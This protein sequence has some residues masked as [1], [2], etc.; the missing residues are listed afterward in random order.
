MGTKIV[1]QHNLA[2]ADTSGHRSRLVVGRAIAVIS[3]SSLAPFAT[4]K[5]ALIAFWRDLARGI[6]SS[7]ACPDR[8]ASIFSTNRL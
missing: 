3:G 8:I 6:A 4:F 5:A 7:T 1:L 2:E